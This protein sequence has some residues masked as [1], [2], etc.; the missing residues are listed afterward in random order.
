[1]FRHICRTISGQLHCKS[2]LCKRLRLNADKELIHLINAKLRFESER[3]LKDKTIDVGQCSSILE[4]ANGEFPHFPIG[5][6]LLFLFCFC[7]VF[8][9]LFSLFASTHFPS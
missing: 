9:I 2:W 7:F 5:L 6:S 8:V 1:M 4:H 3:S